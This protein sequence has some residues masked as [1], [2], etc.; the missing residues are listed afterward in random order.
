MLDSWLGF[1]YAHTK[2]LLTVWMGIVV[3]AAFMSS[4]FKELIVYRAI[5]FS[6]HPLEIMTMGVIKAVFLTVQLFVPVLLAFVLIKLIVMKGKNIPLA[7]TL[8]RSFKR[9]LVI[10]FLVALAFGGLF[11]VDIAASTG[12]S[13]RLTLASVEIFLLAF[14]SVLFTLTSMYGFMKGFAPV[15][16]HGRK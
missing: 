6:I 9:Q 7:R 14:M 4:F 13:S 3:I 5:G 10:S 8:K 2:K 12:A 16:V 15:V 1:F 11:Y